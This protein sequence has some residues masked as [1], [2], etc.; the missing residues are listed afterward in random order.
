MDSLVGRCA[1]CCEY[2]AYLKGVVVMLGKT[3]FSDTMGEYDL[4]AQ[5]IAQLFCN[6][7]TKYDIM[8]AAE[9]LAGSEC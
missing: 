4:I 9:W 8:N 1:G 2:T 7:A 6:F 5:V 3:D